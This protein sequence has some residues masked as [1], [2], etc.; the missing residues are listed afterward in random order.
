ML[1]DQPAAAEEPHFRELCVR[2][3][4]A[5][6]ACWCAAVNPIV[7]DVRVVVLQH[8]REARNPI[9]TA[10]MAHL[11]LPGSTLIEGVSFEHDAKL[12][13]LLGDSSRRVVIL[14]PTEGARDIAGLAGDDD[15]RPITL[16]AID[17]TWSQARS[18]WNKNPRLRALLAV[19]IAPAAPSRY[20]IRKEPAE[21]CLSTIEAIG[22]ALRLL[23]GDDTRFERET[24]LE[25]FEAMVEHQLSFIENPPVGARRH[26]APVSKT[27]Y[28]PRP[29]AELTSLGRHLVLVHGE[30]NGWP[31]SPLPPGGAGDSASHAPSHRPQRRPE[32]PRPALAQWLA[33]RPETGETFH[34]IVVPA[35]AMAPRGL[36]RLEFDER[37]L[38]QAIAQDEF[39]RRW[40]AFAGPQDV[41]ASWAFFPLRLLREAGGAIGAY[42][43][44]QAVASEYLRRRL[45]KLEGAYE[46]LCDAPPLLAGDGAFPGRGGLRIEMLLRI[47]LRL[48]RE[49]T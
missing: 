39:L 10:R 37:V 29:P 5:K 8:P 33:V 41:M 15:Q 1:K 47:T 2:C 43:N 22:E 42:V 9:G 3:R 49:P 25:P 31:S 34:A 48:R 40:R 14:Y 6:A 16:V 11:A 35:T 46:T 18:V 36:E 30:S 38:A 27:P 19:R 28:V 23:H 7:Q 17:G 44:L 26:A 20:R 24:F 21:H 13:T 32:T 12:S 4:R 45:G